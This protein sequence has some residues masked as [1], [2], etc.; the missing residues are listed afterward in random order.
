[1]TIDIK[2]YSADQAIRSVFDP[3]TNTLAV[4]SS[5]GGNL[6]TVEFAQYDYVAVPVTTAAYTEIIASTSD[7]VTKLFIFDSSGQSLYLAT[8]AAASEIDQ[9]IIVPGGNGECSLIIPAGTRI[10]VKAISANAT[11]G[12]L[13]INLLG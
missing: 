5:S 3:I 4:T 6:T 2:E 12:E 9:M 7:A 8:G 11:A 10:S 1:M 13:I